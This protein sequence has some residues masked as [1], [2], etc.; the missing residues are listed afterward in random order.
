MIP[1]F[2][3]LKSLLLPPL[4]PPP[5]PDEQYLAQAVDAADLEYRLRALDERGRDPA[6]GVALGLFPH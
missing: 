3:I 2:H 1:L 5:D 6:T 4:A